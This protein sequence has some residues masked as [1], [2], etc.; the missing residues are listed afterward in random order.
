M[1]RL[2][3]ER[4]VIATIVG[5]VAALGCSKKDN[6]AA[7]TSASMQTVDT[8]TASSTTTTAPDTTS[9]KAA[10]APASKTSTAKKKAPTKPTY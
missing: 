5:A 7:D 10:S 9:S 8:T 3:V 1:R 4:T 6:Y 2:F